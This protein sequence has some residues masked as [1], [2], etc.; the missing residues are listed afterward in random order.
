MLRIAHVPTTVAVYFGMPT[1]D[2]LHVISICVVRRGAWREL[3]KHSSRRLVDLI[4]GPGAVTATARTRAFRILFV[5]MIY[6]LLP[7]AYGIQNCLGARCPC[8]IASIHRRLR[9]WPMF[10]ICLA[11]FQASLPEA[12]VLQ[13]AEGECAHHQVRVG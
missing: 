12:S 2:R 5:P 10:A 6:V 7:S 4:D 9:Y 8:V 1:T 11:S 3:W 13:K